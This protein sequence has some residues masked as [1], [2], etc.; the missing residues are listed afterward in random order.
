M[1]E[2][3]EFTGELGIEPVRSGDGECVMELE[4]EPRHLSMARRVHGGVYFTMLDTVM[5]RAVV[6][7]LPQGRGCATIDAHINYF[8]PA[9]QGRIRA[10]GE[11]VRIT[12]RTAY[13]EGTLLDAEGNMLARSSGTFFLTE[14]L[15]QSDRE[16]V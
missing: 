9:Q 3:K 4:I 5:G 7:R 13:A 8:R 14:T 16:R 1:S 15:E 11:C 2:A 6:S 10:I 12:R